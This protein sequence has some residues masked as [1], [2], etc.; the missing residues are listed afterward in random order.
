MSRNR[1]GICRLSCGKCSSA[2]MH[3][4]WSHGSACCQPQP[5]SSEAKEQ[6]CRCEEQ[7]SSWVAHSV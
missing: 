7:G 4:M 5:W 2:C 6:S 1:P 3:Y